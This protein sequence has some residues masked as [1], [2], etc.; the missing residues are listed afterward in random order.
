M[1]SFKVV[2]Q[3]HSIRSFDFITDLWCFTGNTGYTIYHY[4]IVSPCTN[5]YDKVWS[6]FYSQTLLKY[7]FS[8]S[9]IIISMSFCA[10]TFGNL[11]K[12]S[13]IMCTSF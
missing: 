5:K 8:Q 10:K 3:K 11:N 6:S 13:N 2:R 12:L 9:N 4:K 1:K 7:G